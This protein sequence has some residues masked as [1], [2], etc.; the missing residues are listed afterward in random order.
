MNIKIGINGL[1][2]IGRMLI[3]AI[4]EDKNSNIEINHINNRS[5]SEVACSLMKYDSIHGK[6]DADI[7]FD[8]NNLII[9]KKKNILFTRN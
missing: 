2:R 6:F 7:N 3:R 4:I 1:G 8:N 9:N 5:S